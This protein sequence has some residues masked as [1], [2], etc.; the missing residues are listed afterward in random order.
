MFGYI[1]RRFVRFII[2]IFV[3]M[4]VVFF[5]FRLVPGGLEYTLTGGLGTQTALETMRKKLGLDDPILIQYGRYLFGLLHGDLG[6]SLVY[7]APVIE[8]IVSRL[9]PTLILAGG[10]LLMI[11]V[12]IPIGSYVGVTG[13]TGIMLPL[14]ILYSIPYFVLAL[15]LVTLLSVQL[16]LIPSFGFKGFVSTLL[17]S[18]SIGYPYMVVT[19]RITQ[20][21]VAEVARMDYVSVA[22]AKGV[23][24]WQLVSRHIMRNAII[25]VITSI[26]MQVGYL[27]GGNIIV[28][29]VFA[30]PGIGQ[31]LIQA[32]QA[33]DYPMLQA[34]TILYTAAFQLINLGVDLLYG[35]LDPRI[36]YG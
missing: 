27:L 18:F 9:P 14:F 28:E 13:R 33:R 23:G 5:L 21:S 6:Y 11:L 25:P 15:L 30:W 22:R 8:E 35:F 10:G 24:E 36:Q 34:L 4:T 32:A 7:Q 2:I 29:N 16:K 31:L 12:G 20:V 1:V 17:P 19:A 26:G 3:T